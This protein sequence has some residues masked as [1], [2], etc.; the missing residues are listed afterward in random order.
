M[1]RRAP[2]STGDRSDAPVRD[3]ANHI[4]SFGEV[5]RPIRIDGDAEQ[6]YEPSTGRRSV[7][8]H[9]LRHKPG[10]FPRD[11]A[12]LSLRSD[13]ADE[14]DVD[15]EQVPRAVDR[16]IEECA[17]RRLEAEAGIL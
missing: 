3:L 5:D 10:P 11:G 2:G 6:P 12:H 8:G 1:N 13:L 17:E 15:D 4:V 9:W 14:R 7:H 16:E